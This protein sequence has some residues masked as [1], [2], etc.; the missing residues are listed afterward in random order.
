MSE[1]TLGWAEKVLP[2]EV[3]ILKKILYRNH[4]QHGKTQLFGYLSRIDKTLGAFLTS[5]AIAELDE[6]G[7]KQQQK[8][9]ANSRDV[10]VSECVYIYMCMS[11][12][13]CMGMSVYGC[14]CMSVY[15]DE[16]VWVCMGVCLWVYM[17][18]S[19]LVVFKCL[20]E[21]AFL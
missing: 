12:W 13:V 4:N 20:K 17:G 3:D 10:Q 2:T 16:C 11:V 6:V 21:P 14:M 8:L 19:Y 7:R 1:Y 18:T 15:G 9:K 5:R